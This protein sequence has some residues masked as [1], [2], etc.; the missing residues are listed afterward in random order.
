MNYEE[1]IETISTIV[2]NEKIFKTGLTL[3][4]ELNEKN[5]KQMNE[6]LFYKSNPATAKF[7]ASDEFEVELGGVLVKFVKPKSEEDL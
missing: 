4:Y 2:E 7:I 1:L 5:H 6:Q 3:V